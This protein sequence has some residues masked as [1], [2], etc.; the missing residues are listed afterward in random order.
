[1]DVHRRKV[2]PAKFQNLAAPGEMEAHGGRN[3]RPVPDS[4]SAASIADQGARLE[5]RHNVLAAV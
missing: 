1:M 3:A 2:D 5:R 4:T